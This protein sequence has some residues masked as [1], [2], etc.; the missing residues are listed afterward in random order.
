MYRENSQE[1]QYEDA[2]HGEIC[3]CVPLCFEKMREIVPLTSPPTGTVVV[4]VFVNKEEIIAVRDHE[5]VVTYSTV[6]VDYRA[7]KGGYT[8][9]L[10][11][12][13]NGR[14]YALSSCCVPV[15]RCERPL[16]QYSTS[17][18]LEQV[19]YYQGLSILESTALMK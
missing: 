15:R 16:S 3:V 5:W 9:L 14:D 6:A 19:I 12:D 8:S 4:V 18:S 7:L 17:T 1:Q 10:R 11:W 2:H 13:A